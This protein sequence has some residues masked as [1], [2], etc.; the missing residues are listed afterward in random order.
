MQLSEQIQLKFSPALSVLCHKTKNLYNLAMYHYRQFYFA[1]GEFINYY[2]LQEILKS[3]DA[4]KNLPA[5]TS[6][7][8]LDLVIKSWRSY[9]KALQAYKRDPSKF[10]GKP[11]FPKYKP[12]NGEFIAIFTNQNARIRNNTIYFPKSCGLTPIKTRIKKFQQIRIIP[13]G[14]GYMCEVIYNREEQDLHLNKDHIIALDLGINN[15]VTMVNNIGITPMIIKGG[16]V[17]SIN[18]HYNKH[19]AFLQSIKDKQGM[20]K[21]TKRQKRIL[22]KRNNRIQDIF[23]TTSAWIINLCIQNNIGTIVIGYNEGWKQ[24]AHMG[25]QNNQN[26]VQI[27]FAKLISMCEYKARLVGIQVIT[28]EESYTSKC[29]FL[30]NE[31][32]EEQRRYCGRR[33]YRGLFRSRNGILINSDVNGAYNIMRKVIPNALAEGIE[34]VVLNPILVRFDSFRTKINKSLAVC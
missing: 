17:K 34:G 2:D 15:L 21:Q 10:V 30:D 11:R 20:G 5:Q 3:S 24:R 25:T 16:I 28:H 31:P 14:I 12:K 13:Q 1:L 6:Q 4:Y 18:Q 23:H 7:Q 22:R 32:I 8:I 27:P 9:W 26:F 33:V 29:S 19:N